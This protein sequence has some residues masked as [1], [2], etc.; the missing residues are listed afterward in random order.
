MRPIFGKNFLRKIHISIEI[1]HNKISLF[2]FCK[3]ITIKLLKIL[4]FSEGLS[5]NKKI[6][7]VL[8]KISINICLSE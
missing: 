5:I 6:G 7:N 2:A 1:F 3:K 8:W 4:D